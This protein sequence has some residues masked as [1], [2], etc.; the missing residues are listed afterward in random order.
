[1]SCNLKAAKSM[2]QNMA[3]CFNIAYINFNRQCGYYVTSCQTSTT[4]GHVT[5]AG[6]FVTWD[7]Q[8]NSLNAWK[9]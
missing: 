3:S 4:I 9:R 5:K 2:A 7:M 6:K 8:K 1:M